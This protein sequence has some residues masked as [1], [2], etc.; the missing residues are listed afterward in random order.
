MIKFFFF[1]YTF[2]LIFIYLAGC[3]TR[4]VTESPEAWTDE[5]AENWFTR[6]EWLGSVPFEPDPSINKKEF[7][8]RYHEN[9]ERWETAFAYLRNEDLLALKPGEYEIEG[10][11]VY[12]IISE[13]S[14]KNREETHFESHEKYTDIQH[15]VSGVEFIEWA[16]IANATIKTPYDAG[17]DIALYNSRKIKK[18]QAHPGNFFIFFPSDV[19]RPSIKVESNAPVRKI[20][21]KVRN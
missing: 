21:I 2:S 4:Q 11:N 5:Q 19:H 16:D 7:A 15:L 12:A 17:N 6:K 14:S 13:Y 9:Q 8:R 3:T 20:V 1:Y 10:K 18:L